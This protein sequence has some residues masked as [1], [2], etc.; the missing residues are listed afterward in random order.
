MKTMHGWMALLCALLLAGCTGLPEGVRPVGDFRLADYLGRWYEI[1]R[2]DHA[3][4]RGLTRVSAEYSLRDDG[5]IRV[6]NRGYSPQAG[7]WKEAAGVA[8]FAGDESVGHLEV[9][10]FGPFYA[11]YVVFEI[12]PGYQY[13]FVTSHD[14]SYLWLLARTPGVAPAVI[15]RFLA[16]SRALGY[17][18]G[19]L[20]F[21][22]QRPPGLPA[23]AG[24]DG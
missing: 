10:F 7:A 22:E 6:V 21:V 13:A 19:K 4:E 20:I 9:S 16:R 24:P 1:A 2:L 23:G 18:T 11:S 12:D 14:K 5:T 17:D 8:R 3:F 15:E